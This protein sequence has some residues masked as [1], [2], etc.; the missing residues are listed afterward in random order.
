VGDVDPTAAARILVVDDTPQNL[1]LVGAVLRGSGY[2]LSAARSGEEALM[3]AAAAPPDLI[4]LD[5]GMPGID[6]FAT[7]ARLKSHPLFADTPVIFLTA[8]TDS[9]SVVRGFAVG[10]VDYVAKPF[11]AEE[12]LARV[13]THLDLR[14]ARRRLVDLA[15]KLG[16]YL[17]P[18]VYASIFAGDR[19]VRIESYRRDLTVFFSDI[20]Q[21]TRSTE[22]MSEA[23]LTGWLNGYLDEMARIAIAF[24]GTLDKFIGDGVMVFFATRPATASAPTRRRA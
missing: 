19:E 22:H 9:D 1:K 10:G 18:Q 21:F 12:L 2:R 20:V 6:G 13:R 14:S 17:S 24:G 16:R 5:V 3:A 7:C 8:H 11:R 23:A 15:D 4:L